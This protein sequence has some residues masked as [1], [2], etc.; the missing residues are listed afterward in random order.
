VDAAASDVTRDG[1]PV[2]VYLA[3]PAA[4]EPELI[5]A[6]VP[7]GASILEL[8]SG[9]GRIAAPLATRLR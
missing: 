7:P 5:H 3:L 8:A 2:A 6:A 1:S 4:G 9:P